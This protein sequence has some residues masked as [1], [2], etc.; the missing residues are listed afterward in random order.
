MPLPKIDSTWVLS[1][2][3]F[4]KATR[5]ASRI[6][7]MDYIRLSED[8]AVPTLCHISLVTLFRKHP[9]RISTLVIPLSNLPAS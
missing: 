3:K 1:C 9:A 5:Q 6:I 8:L 4:S 7:R 2:G